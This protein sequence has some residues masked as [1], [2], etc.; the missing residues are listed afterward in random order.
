MVRNP[1]FLSRNRKPLKFKAASVLKLSLA[2]DKNAA[3]PLYFVSNAEFR[4]YHKMM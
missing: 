1:T 2:L 4:Q 3:F